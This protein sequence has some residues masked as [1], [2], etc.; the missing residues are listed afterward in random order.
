MFAAP[1]GYSDLVDHQTNFFNAVRSRK[2]V[3]ENEEFGNNA[4]L[5]GCTWRTTLTLKIQRQCGMRRR[6]RL[7]VKATE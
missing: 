7:E 3:V 4:Q 2:K 6:E 5:S 1:E